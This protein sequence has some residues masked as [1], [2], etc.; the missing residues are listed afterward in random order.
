M[1]ERQ[2]QRTHGDSELLDEWVHVVNITSIS[3][4]E[5]MAEIFFKMLRLK[6]SPES[7][8]AFVYVDFNNCGY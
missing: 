4:R 8:G 6:Y 7:Q 1:E 3:E 5:S 2:I